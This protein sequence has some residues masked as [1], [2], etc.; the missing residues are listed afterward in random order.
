MADLYLLKKFSNPLSVLY[1]EDNEELRS[2]FLEYLK[3]FFGAITVCENGQDGL[4][5]F[6]QNK[7]DIV[8]TDINMPKMNGLDMSK[9]IKEIAPSQHII[10]ISAYKDI[11]NYI[12]AIKIGIDGYILK[13]IEYNQVN[14]I[15]LKVAKNLH[16]IRENQLYKEHLEHLVQEQTKEL[17]RHY[18]TDQLTGLYNK[19]HLEDLLAQNKEGNTLIL[20]N[21][22]N[23]SIINHNFG[24]SIGDQFL[25]SVATHLKKFQKN[26]FLLHR[27]Q[28][29]EFAF[30]CKGVEIEKAIDLAKEIKAFSVNNEFKCKLITLTL[31]F[32]FAINGSKTEDVLK[33]ASLTMQETRQ[34]S[35]NTIAVYTKNSLF[36]QQQKNNLKNIEEVK[37]CIREKSFQILFQPLQEIQTQKIRKYEAL[38]RVIGRDG[39][40]VMPNDF[41]PTLSITGLITKFTRIVIHK[42]FEK[43]SGTN[44]V[45]TINITSQDLKEN[46]L[47]TYLEKK[48]EEFNIDT[49]Q[50]II[51]ILESVSTT[52]ESEFIKQFQ[53]FKELGY[54]IAIDDFG[55]EHSNFARLLTFK[56]D[57]I[58]I[59]GS[60]IKNIV[61][62]PNSK[63]IAKAITN[64]AHNIGCKVVA[65]FVADEDIYNTVKELNVDFAQ[66]YYI[67]KPEAEFEMK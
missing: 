6:K 53:D 35:K 26:N 46:Y 19:T 21:V 57:F 28:G 66:G 41:L 15:L 20:L 5:K 24:F 40:I 61:T 64:F 55:T 33:N 37:W 9:E 8:I 58:K 42:A 27:L 12:E 7:Y 67:R 54:R 59:D 25:E 13:P 45:I 38:S 22:D 49:S 48:R 14:N 1:V 51:E 31:T 4:E 2:S 34:N 56:P 11:E 65:E 52:N 44:Y 3:S 62:D 60:F 43:L 29:D 63:E 18:I 47:V 23:F 30:V 32:T 36:E 10:I 39:E 16:N 17:K 50:V